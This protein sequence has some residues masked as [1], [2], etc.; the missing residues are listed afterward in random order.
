MS[1]SSERRVL[2][3]ATALAIAA[4]PLAACTD[5]HYDRRDT[6]SFHAGDAIAANRVQQTVDMWPPD[7]NRTRVPLNG[8]RAGLA[9]ER[10]KTNTSIPPVGL[11]T[12]SVVITPSAPPASAPPPPAQ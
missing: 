6:I 5:A 8:N 4:I 11:G 7:A 10:Y 12:S 2:R 9:M 3:I 1:Q